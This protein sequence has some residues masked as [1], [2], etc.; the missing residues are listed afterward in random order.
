[1]THGA[2]AQKTKRF[3]RSFELPEGDVQLLKLFR[4]TVPQFIQ[5]TVKF[6]RIFAGDHP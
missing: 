3:Q 5:L 6:I 4:Q 2:S 1:L